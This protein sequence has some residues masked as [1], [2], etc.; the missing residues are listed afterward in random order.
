MKTFGLKGSGRLDDIQNLRD[1]LQEQYDRNTRTLTKTT[2]F[3]ADILVMFRVAS[4]GKP[5]I[6]S[7]NLYGFYKQLKI[8]L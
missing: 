4:G 6:L 5:H 8:G 1:Y 7:N 2:V 3:K